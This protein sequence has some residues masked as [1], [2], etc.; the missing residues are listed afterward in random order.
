M[1]EWKAEQDQPA[2]TL[3]A[4]RWYAMSIEKYA[5]DLYIT[6]REQYPAVKAIL[7]NA[8][9]SLEQVRSQQSARGEDAGCPPGFKNCSGICLP[10]CVPGSQ[11]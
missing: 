9:E 6:N 2:M 1:S 5:M 11:Y 7:D 8:L 3:A 10:D 4:I